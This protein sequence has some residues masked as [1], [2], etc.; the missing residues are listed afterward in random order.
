MKPP[1][2]TN[3]LRRTG[4]A[5][6]GGL[7]GLQRSPS[8]AGTPVASGRSCTSSQEHNATYLGPPRAPSA[9]TGLMHSCSAP[10]LTPRCPPAE[11][12]A[13]NKNVRTKRQCQP[14]E[15]LPK[16]V[17]SDSCSHLVDDTWPH[18]AVPL[19]VFS[20]NRDRV[21]PAYREEVTFTVREEKYINFC[22][23]IRCGQGDHYNGGTV[24]LVYSRD[25]NEAPVGA[26]GQLITITD[27]VVQPNNT[28]IITA[29]G[30]VDFRITRTWMPRGLQGLQMAFIEAKDF[31]K[32]GLDPITETAAT[33]CKMTAFAD[34]LK[35]APR[36]WEELGSGGPF[37]AFVPTNDGLANL[38]IS[39]DGLLSHPDLE[40]VLRSHICKGKVVYEQMYSG[41]TFQ[42]LDGTILQVTFGRWPR[43]NPSINGVP[44]E[45]LDVLCSNGVIHSI[46]GLLTSSPAHGRRRW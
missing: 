36:L 41:R 34:L 35:A 20:G 14:P 27:V 1:V 12:V 31:N 24:G 38:G 8:S 10:T 32:G 3:A 26:E 43:G 40:A 11:H 22:V 5:V 4:A 39:V 30:D 44:F 37:T 45:H 28:I 21:R 29:V 18:H 23:R 42:A 33:E 2:P 19:W 6:L 16:A 9:R 17:W 15:G 46:I 13:T 7:G 25:G